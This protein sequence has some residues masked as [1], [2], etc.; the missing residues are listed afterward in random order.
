MIICM[1]VV[2]WEYHNF[3]GSLQR[4]TI[5]LNSSTFP[6]DLSFCLVVVLW[7]Y[8]CCQRNSPFTAFYKIF[9]FFSESCSNYRSWRCIVYLQDDDAMIFQRLQDNVRFRLINHFHVYSCHID[10]LQIQFWVVKVYHILFEDRLDF[11]DYLNQ[12]VLFYIVVDNF[13]PEHVDVIG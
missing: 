7:D 2:A 4:L 8:Q 10:H 6:R 13:I 5:I 11:R 1:N 3:H 12:R 9:P